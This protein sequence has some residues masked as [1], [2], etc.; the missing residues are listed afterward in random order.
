MQIPQYNC[1]Q[2]F[3]KRARNL[4]KLPFDQRGPLHGIPFSVK[5]HFHF[6]GREAT[7]GLYSLIG[8]KAQ[9]NA[10]IGI[11]SANNYTAGQKIQNSP[12]KKTRKIK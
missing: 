1:S 4:D 11:F 7:A 5:E 3:L 9:Q 8:Q 10:Q 2:F 6:K 12:G